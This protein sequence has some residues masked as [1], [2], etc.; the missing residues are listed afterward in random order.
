MKKIMLAVA[1]FALMTPLAQAQMKDGH[2]Y[3]RDQ[4]IISLQKEGWVTTTSANVGVYFDIIQQKETALELKNLILGSLKKLS[5]TTDWRITSSREN[6]DRT[7]LNRWHVTA[8]ARVS[9][10]SVSGLNDRAEKA[11][12][13]GFN[14]RIGHVNFT[15]SLAETEKV[16][17]ELRAEIYKEAAAEA[18]R[19]N[20]TIPGTS[21]KIFMIDFGQMAYRANP[22]ALRSR[23]AKSE[24]AMVSTMSSQNDQAG[25][26]AELAVSRRQHMSATVILT[27]KSKKKQ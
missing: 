4:V 18:E 9:E 3:K 20:Q 6:K 14:M 7:G 15:P 16:K 2:G 26:G 5:E 8:E 1:L 25:G 10:Q 27:S 21:Y 13:P 17:G 12:R 19:L 23:A 22:V 11:S 24:Q